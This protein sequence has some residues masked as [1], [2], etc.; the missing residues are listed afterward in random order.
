MGP[1]D[2]SDLSNLRDIMNLKIARPI[3]HASLLV[4]QFSKLEGVFVP[5]FEPAHFAQSGRWAQAQ[6][7]A[8]RQLPPQKIAR[9]GNT[10]TLDYAQAGLRFTTTIANAADIGAQYYYGRR[11]TPSLTITASPQAPPVVTIP[12][13]TSLRGGLNALR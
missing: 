8:L 2:Y 3:V 6:F 10:S 13:G 1:L 7:E 11:N 5:G 4:G 9:P 12:Q